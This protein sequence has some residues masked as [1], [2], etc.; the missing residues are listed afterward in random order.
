MNYQLFCIWMHHEGEKSFKKTYKRLLHFVP[1]IFLLYMN[2][3]LSLNSNSISSFADKS[4]LH[5]CYSSCK[6]ISVAEGPSSND[7]PSAHLM[8][9]C[10]P[11][12]EWA[13][14]CTFYWKNNLLITNK[15]RKVTLSS[16]I[17]DNISRISL[18]VATSKK[19]LIWYAHVSNFPKF[20]ASLYS[21]F[22]AEVSSPYTD[23]IFATLLSI[24]FT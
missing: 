23:L 7:I 4:F 14:P 8:M 11:Q 19:N 1:T 5:S 17:L 3:L 10:S 22:S 2:D 13:D 24:V 18:V 21:F 9:Y 20:W 15:K 12:M 6:H 16:K